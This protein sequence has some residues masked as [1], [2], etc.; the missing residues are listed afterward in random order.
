MHLFCLIFFRA[1]SEDDPLTRMKMVVKWYLSGYYK[2]PKG[3]KKPYN[4]I[5]GEC[6]R[7][8]WKHP[9]T[10]SRTFYIAEQVSHHPPVSAFYATN[11]KEGYCISGSILAKSRFYGNSVSALLDGTVKLTFLTR[12]EDY[13]ITLPYAH[14]KGILLGTL[15][16]ELGGK[17]S[18]KCEKTG[19]FT[20]LEFKLKPFLGGSELCNNVIGKIKLGKETLCTL[21]GHWDS[22][23]K[24]KDKRTSQEVVLWSALEEAK[25]SRL[26]RYNVVFEYQ[27]D[28]E[29]EK[30]WKNVTNA[31]IKGDQFA[32][33]EEKTLLEEEQRRAAKERLVKKEKWIPRNFVQDIFTGEWIY[34]HVDSRPW[35]PRTD[36]LQY[37]RN[38]IIQTKTR[39][40]TPTVGCRTNSVV[41]MESSNPDPESAAALLLRRVNRGSSNHRSSP[42][43]KYDAVESE[44]SSSSEFSKSKSIETKQDDNYNDGQSCGSEK[45]TIKQMIGHI[46]DAL[47]SIQKNIDTILNLQKEA[48]LKR[49]KRNWSQKSINIKDIFCII[50]ISLFTQLMVNIF[51]FRS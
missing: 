29:S 7:C 5:L 21:D 25:K 30:L 23:M 27:Y 15:S 38:Y 4:P 13:T 28:F 34:K 10:R 51:L 45:Q 24:V 42:H 20:E 31:I 48:Y 3:L 43:R 16:F 50:I 8:Y 14:C 35:D 1:N 18:I 33:T 37:E 39:H 46:Q 36:V 49:S 19:Y 11:R 26:K 22:V 32:A 6:L 9:E 17:V 44:E 12:G 41:N 40:K 47:G 2:K